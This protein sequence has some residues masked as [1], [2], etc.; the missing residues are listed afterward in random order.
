MAQFRL[1]AYDADVFVPEFLGLRQNDVGL[2]PD[3]RYA[4]EARNVETPNGI[5]QPRAANVLLAGEFEERIETLLRFHRRYYQGEGTKDFLV[6]AVGGALYEKQ[7]GT[8]TWYTIDFPGDLTTFQSN[9]WSWVTYEI[10][11]DGSDFPVDVLVISN[12]V[13][14][15]FLIVPSDIGRT[16]GTLKKLTWGNIKKHTWDWMRNPE[17]VILPVDTKGN[18]FSVIE[19]H[20]ERIWGGGIIGKEDY[21]YYSA[22][23]DPLDWEANTEIPEDGAGEIMLPSWD[24]DKFTTLRVFGEQLIAFKK[25]KLWRI[26]GTNPGEYDVR[27]QYGGGAPYPN[28]VVTHEERILIADRD[29]MSIYDGMSVS[30]YA[31]EAVEVLWKTVNRDAMSQMCACIY[32]EKYYLALPVGESLVNNAL[33]IYDLQRGTILYHDGIYIENM[34]ATDERLYATSST[35]PGKVME[36]RYDSWD[37]GAACGEEVEWV[38]PWMDFGRKDIQ[39]GGFDLYFIPEVQEEAVT[40]SISIQTEKKLKTKTYTINPLTEAQRLVQRE[41]RGKRLHFGGSGRKFRVII[42]AAEGVT[43]PWRLIGG[44]HIIAETDPD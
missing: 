4:A 9:V 44:L 14:G 40:L 34:L 8:D 39:K 35:V 33:L 18:K 25:W 31:R 22:P 7:E 5:L 38:S 41:H 3:L 6:A 10:N 13:D 2:V 26:I 15:M 28:T 42:R 36:L 19:R 32:R 12:A 27:E 11:I 30:P 43:A 1:N 23:Y 29:G 16:W 21:L 17:W 24:G 37:V 20:E